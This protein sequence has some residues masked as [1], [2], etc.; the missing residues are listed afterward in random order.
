[1][2]A[3]AG[4]PAGPDLAS[5]D[6]ILVN[7]S[8]GKDSQAM[9]DVVVEQAAAAGV[10][11]RIVVVHCDLGRAEWPGTREL[12]MEH[13]QHYGLKWAVVRARQDLLEGIRARRRALDA[14]GRKDTPAWPS[15]TERYCTS[16]W[17]RGPVRA[18]MTKLADE[19]HGNKLR[20]VLAPFRTL[21]CLGMR[22]EESTARS[23]LVPFQRD[24]G[25]SNGRR[26]VDTWLPIH[27]WYLDEVWARCRQVGTRIHYAYALGMPRVSCC[28]CIFAPREAL[29]LAGRHNPELLAEYV[30]IEEETGHTFKPRLSLRVLR[31]ELRAGAACGPVPDWAM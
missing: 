3:R 30:A 1:M 17:K 18:L 5:Y 10:R 6:V 26:H 23:K 20:R 31:D 24:R 2:F 16:G 4:A 29:L 27:G 21:N 28:L 8:A 15:P 19:H 22:A 25:A 11:D 9:L 14:S 12:A 7:S 13:A